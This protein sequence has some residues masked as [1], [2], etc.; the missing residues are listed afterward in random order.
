MGQKAAS[1]CQAQP[2]GIAKAIAAHEPLKMLVRE[3]D[4][5]IA[6]RPAPAWSLPDWIQ[7]YHPMTVP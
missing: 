1:R 5:D 2:A 3:I 7:T 4:Y 6:V